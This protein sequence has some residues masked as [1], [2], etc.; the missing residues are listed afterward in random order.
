LSG[1][2]EIHDGVAV[3]VEVT[4]LALKLA[5]D[6]LL[7]IFGYVLDYGKFSRRVIEM[8]LKVILYTQSCKT[9]ALKLKIK[10]NDDATL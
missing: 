6:I 5:E 9:Y 7:E 3:E 10:L 2:T 1:V 4:V 8:E